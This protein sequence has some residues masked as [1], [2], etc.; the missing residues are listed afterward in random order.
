[1]P[2]YYRT[3]PDAKK[4]SAR[5]SKGVVHSPYIS[6]AEIQQKFTLVLRENVYDRAPYS[7]ALVTLF[8]CALA[9][10]QRGL[11]GILI[12]AARLGF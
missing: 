10:G 4:S 12:L 7:A 8:S 6:S 2:M 11:T 1:M 5:S 3:M 9:T